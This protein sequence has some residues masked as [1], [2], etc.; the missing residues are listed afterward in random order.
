MKNLIFFIFLMCSLNLFSQNND[1][2]KVIVYDPFNANQT[3]D[4]TN[5]VYELNLIK[6]N[7]GMLGRGAFEIDFERCIND[8]FT[9]ELGVGITYIDITKD[10]NI[11]RVNDNFSFENTT[12]K[13]GPLFM[14]DL[15]FYPRKVIGFDGFYISVP[16]RYRSYF[17]EKKLTYHVDNNSVTEIFLNNSRH[18]EYGFIVGSQSGDY[19]DVTWD[20]FFGMGLN[21]SY[22]NSPVT[23]YNNNKPSQISEHQVRPV[24]FLGVKMGFAF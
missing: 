11:L 4:P 15:K 3:I 19:W 18:F 22:S 10:I 9:F 17:A 2:A 20:W 5:K 14:A 21:S 12:F 6:W 8:N 24:I 13:Y 7:I 23:D 16:I 1:S